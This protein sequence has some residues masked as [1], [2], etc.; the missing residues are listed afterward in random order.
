VMRGLGSTPAR[1]AHVASWANMQ[2]LGTRSQA[3]EEDT[4]RA[5]ESIETFGFR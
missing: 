1:A 5:S 3:W 2:S 4:Q